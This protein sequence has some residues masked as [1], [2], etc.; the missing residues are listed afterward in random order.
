MNVYLAMQRAGLRT[1]SNLCIAAQVPAG[2]GLRAAGGV[3][4]I[5]N[6]L[7]YP[8]TCFADVGP[9]G[10]GG[11]RPFQ[12]TS[13]SAGEQIAPLESVHTAGG[14]VVVVLTP[15]FQYLKWPGSPFQ[16]MK[17]N[18][19]VQPRFERPFGYLDHNMDRVEVV[20]L[21]RIAERP[22]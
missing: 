11:Y 21:A 9:V 19:M 12:V 1:A 16:S 10:R 8:V 3:C 5:A 7:E 4:R 15:P 18:R 14:S 22:R 6:I 2:E 13:L 20:P 17:P